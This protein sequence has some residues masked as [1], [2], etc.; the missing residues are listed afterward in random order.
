MDIKWINRQNDLI[1]AWK[2]WSLCRLSRFSSN[3]MDRTSMELS[4]SVE[5]VFRTISRMFEIISKF[6]D[7][8]NSNEFI[9]FSSQHSTLSKDFTSNKRKNVEPIC[10]TLSNRT[11]EFQRS[12][13]V[14]WESNQRFFSFI[15]TSKN[16]ISFESCRWIDSK[17]IVL[18]RLFENRWKLFSAIVFKM[19]NGVEFSHQSNRFWIEIDW[20][21]S[22]FCWKT[23]EIPVRLRSNFN[24]R[25][26]FL[27]LW[28][29][30]SS[31]D[32]FLEFC[33]TFFVC[34]KKNI[35]CW[36]WNSSK[37]FCLDWRSIRFV[38][39][40]E[41]ERKWK[42]INRIFCSI[43][44]WCKKRMIS[45]EQMTFHRR[46]SISLMWLRRPA[47]K[48]F[49]SWIFVQIFCDSI[50]CFICSVRLTKPNHVYSFQS[51][52]FVTFLSLIRTEQIIC[53]FEGKK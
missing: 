1:S 22:N 44:Y 11:I 47:K 40:W 2:F 6:S 43:R 29:I 50:W 33:W 41:S 10:R 49:E 9:L 16:W 42:K 32:S 18:F 37:Y 45:F 48:K 3:E 28:F 17:R 24:E 15:S 19:W 31:I 52:T 46:K 8:N 20:N 34:K 35:F 12:T 14:R 36:Q 39:C 23:N 7:S 5:F 13:F 26:K 27:F 53:L 51:E 38:K 25:W 30:V 21:R 4:K